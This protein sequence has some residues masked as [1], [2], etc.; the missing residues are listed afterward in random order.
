M[1]RLILVDNNDFHT[2]EDI[3]RYVELVKPD[4]FV[5]DF[6]TQL[7][8]E[9]NDASSFNYGVMATA[10]K[11]KRLVQRTGT[12]GILI[13]QLKKGTIEQRSNK[14]PYLD[15][16][17][18]SGTIKQ[19]AAVVLFTFFPKTY[20]GKAVPETYF[21]VMPKKSRF[22]ELSPLAL[23]ATPSYSSF[24]IENT[25]DMSVWLE[26]YFVKLSKLS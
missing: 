25:K 17:E 11:I 19:L 18:W 6:V 20:Y 2:A 9:A 5:I 8:T 3:S 24:N 16:M 22:N 26:Q 1:N 14:V 15:D 13:T 7:G 23:H 10:N 12:C 4:L 21:Y